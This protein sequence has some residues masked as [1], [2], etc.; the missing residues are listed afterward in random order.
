MKS[1]DSNVYLEVYTLFIRIRHF[2]FKWTNYIED[3]LI[4]LYLDNDFLKIKSKIKIT[5]M[6]EI[7]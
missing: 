7:F 5:L 2:I 3:H 1:S 6:I 4:G